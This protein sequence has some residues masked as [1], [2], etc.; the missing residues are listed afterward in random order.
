MNYRVHISTKDGQVISAIVANR[1]AVYAG[2]RNYTAEGGM[3]V[4]DV[5]GAILFVPADEVLAVTAFPIKEE[6][7]L[8]EESPDC[9]GV[10]DRK[11][12]PHPF[13]GKVTREVAK[14]AVKAV[15]S[16][17]AKDEDTVSKKQG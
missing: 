5:K 6:E 1:S 2:I 17:K 12:L 14:A 4:V 11:V 3:A 15:K 16:K 8:A 10:K 7:V 9:C 13:E